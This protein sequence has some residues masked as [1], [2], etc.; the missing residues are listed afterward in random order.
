MA[1]L[2]KGSIVVVKW[3]DGK[4]YVGKIA[5]VLPRGR[6]KIKFEDGDVAAKR[7]KSILITL[8]ASEYKEFSWSILETGEE[9]DRLLEE[10]K[11]L[12][13]MLSTART[14]R[15][16]LR[17]KLQAERDKRRAELPRNLREPQRSGRHQSEIA[18]PSNSVIYGD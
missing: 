1:H 4:H 14:E 12:R 6:F 7:T 9:N 3:N 17:E 2:E 13:D 5:K 8:N 10:N 18:T 11:K 15:D 16:Q